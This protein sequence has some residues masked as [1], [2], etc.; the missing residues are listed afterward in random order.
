MQQQQVSR[1]QH[2]R[3]VVVSSPLSGWRTVELLHHFG[4]LAAG[5]VLAL[6]AEEVVQVEL[7][8]VRVKSHGL[9]WKCRTSA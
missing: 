5:P 3:P 1:R 6:L 9:L 7:G 4:Q 8:S 2:K